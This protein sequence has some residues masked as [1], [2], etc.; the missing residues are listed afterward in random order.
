MMIGTDLAIEP[1]E[2]TVVYAGLG[3][4]LL[5]I[6][7]VNPEGVRGAGAFL[8]GVAL[9]ASILTWV[10]TPLGGRAHAGTVGGWEF[11]VFLGVWAALQLRRLS[12]ADAVPTKGAERRQPGRSRPVRRS[13][14]VG[15][16]ITS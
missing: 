12:H 15:P 2:R 11:V 10:V 13:D 16:D 6:S 5:V 14:P 7:F 4:A 3:A 9:S 1:Y 8:V